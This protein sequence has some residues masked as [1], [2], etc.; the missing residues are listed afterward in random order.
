MLR[1]ALTGGLGSGKSTAAQ[2]FAQHGAYLLS[3]DEI[4]RNLMQPGQAV[5]E[6]IVR[7]FGPEVVSKTGELDRV[8]L[9][10]MAFGEGR[11]EELNA[12]VHPATI[13]R[14][15]ELT[16]EICKRDP[17]AVVMVESALVFET[18]HGGDEGWHKRF[19]WIVLVRAPEEQRIARFVNRMAG[20]RDLNKVEREGLEAEARRRICQQWS[21]EQKAA[22]SDSVIWNDGSVE[23][24]YTQ[25]DELW[26][27]LRGAAHRRG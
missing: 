21:D 17:D 4:G 23:K 24:L 7:R 13:A 11:L 16:A 6:E 27:V 18:R 26:P 10:K 19:D 5:Y 2:R 9:A 14:Q 25:V 1:V 22:H 15:A 8:A 20:L 3:A 12:I